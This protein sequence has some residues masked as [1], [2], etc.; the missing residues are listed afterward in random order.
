MTRATVTFVTHDRAQ[1]PVP[2]EIPSGPGVRCAVIAHRGASKAEQ[3]NTLSAFR[4]A[5]EMEADG[6]EL[7]VRRALDGALVVHHDP[8]LSDGRAIASVRSSE[9]P[10][11][12]PALH[13]ALDAC[14][15]L[16]VNVEIK[17]DPSEPDFDPSDDIAAA[18]AAELVA[19]NEPL[20]FLVS[21]FR[22]ET[23]DRFRNEAPSIATA[24]LTPGVTPHDMVE[25]LSGLQ[26]DGHAAIHPWF[27]L[28]GAELV[29]AA[30]I[31]G[32]MVNVWTCDDP[33]KIRELAGIGVDG[34]CTN[35]P[36]L[37]VGVLFAN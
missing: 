25:V 13:E 14:R 17:N 1:A 29:E 21:S 23:I 12:V 33:D 35:V 3:E 31:H 20:R 30:H 8:C 10:S 6:V 16:W 5:V 37:A 4:R 36:N 24:W 11:H 15:P 18:V 27:G 32:L 7:D 19:R 9:L 28:V 22:R 34:I 26:R 2:R